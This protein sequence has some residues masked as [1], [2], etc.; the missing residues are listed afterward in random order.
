MVGEKLGA[1]GRERRVGEKLL[2]LAR[3]WQRVEA[4][5]P[6]LVEKLPVVP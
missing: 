5:E 4:V 6:E 3:L 2:D 1:L